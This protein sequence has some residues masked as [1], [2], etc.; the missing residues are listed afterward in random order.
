M[1]VDA[2]TKRVFAVGDT[3][4]TEPIYLQKA[5]VTDLHSTGSDDQILNIS[6]NKEKK[7]KKRKHAHSTETAER[8]LKSPS[9][10]PKR[11]IKF[12]L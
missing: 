11:N 7:K 6:A 10:T 8:Q 5:A 12:N 1:I 9:T 2:M 4:K 3:G